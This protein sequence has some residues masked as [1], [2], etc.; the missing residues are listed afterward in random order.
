[1]SSITAPVR[2]SAWRRLLLA[3][4]AILAVVLTGVVVPTAASAVESALRIDKKVDGLELAELVPGDEF[5]YTVDLTCLDEDCVDVELVDTLPA[6]LAGFRLVGASYEPADLPLAVD[7]EGCVEDGSGAAVEVTDDCSFRVDFLQDLGDGAV[8]LIAGGTLKLSLVL[9]VPDDLSPDWP[10]NGATITN[11]SA[12]SWSNGPGDLPASLTDGADVVITVAEVIDVEASKEWSPASQQFEPGDVSTITLGAQNLSNLSAEALVVQD[13]MSAVDGAAELGADNPFRIVDFQGFGAQALPADATTVTVDAYV[14]DT[15]SETW[16]WV[17]GAAGA[18]PALPTGVEPADVGGVRLTFAGGS[19]QPDATASTAFTVAQ[20]AADRDSGATLSGGASL[21]N[22]VSATVVVPGRDGVSDEATAPFEVGPLTVDVSGSKSIEPGELPAGG[23]ATA[24]LGVVN[25]SNGP[26]DALTISDLGFFDADMAFGGFPDGIG[27]PTGATEASIVWYVDGAPLPAEAF[28]DGASPP[29]PAGTVTGFVVE[30]RGDIPAGEGASL[31]ATIEP[32]LGLVTETERVHRRTNTIDVTATNAVG[33]AADDASDEIVVYYPEI[34]IALDKAIRPGGA[35]EPGNSVVTSLTATTGSGVAQVDPTHIAVEDSWRED[36]PDDF[37]NAFDIAG[38]AP[39]QVPPRTTLTVEYQRPDGSWATAAVVPPQDGA[40]IVQLSRAELAAALTAPDTLADVTGIR[41]SFDNPEG[42]PQGFS[43]IPNV[44]FDARS[45][46]RDG[47]GPVDPRD[48]PEDSQAAQ[49]PTIYENEATAQSHGEVEGLP[50]GIDSELVDAHD[51]VGVQTPATGVGPG[52]DVRKRWVDAVDRTADVDVVDAQSGA[53]VTTRNEWRTGTPGLQTL[54]LSDPAAAPGTDPAEPADTVF[55]AFDL[56]R[57]DRITLADDPL[58]AWDDV[59][60]VWLF[61]DGAWT[62][63]A[64]DGGTWMDPD[65]SFRGHQLTPEQS[66]GTTGVRLVYVPDDAARAASSD[67]TRPEAGSGIARSAVDQYRP[68]LLTWQLRNV[69]RDPAGLADP[70]VTQGQSFNDPDEGTVWNSLR[71]DWTSTAGSGSDVDRDAIALVDQ[72]PLV[73][74]QKRATPSSVTVPEAADVDPADYPT[75]DF[76]L[77][78]TNDST[79]RASYLRVTDPIPCAAGQADECVSA[80]DAWDGDP[81]AGAAYDPARNPYEWLAVRSLSFT[82]PA[83]EVDPASSTVTLWDRAPDGALSTRT[84]SATAAEGLD[85]AA[86]ETVVGVS[87]VFQGAAPETSGGTIAASSQVGVGIRTQVRQFER[88]DPGELVSARRIDNDAIAQSYDPVLFPS[89]AASTPADQDGASVQLRTG[90]LDVELAKTIAPD[91]LLE[92]G[93]GTPVRV[94]LDAADGDSTVA[95]QQVTIADADPGFWNAIRL[96]DAPNLAVVLPAGADQV[97]VDALVDGAWVEGVFAASAVLP[98]VPAADVTGLRAV[99]RD[100]AGE[101][102]SR[103]SPPADWQARLAFDVLVLTTQ[104]DGAELSLPARFHN[105]AT[106]S[107]ER[108]DGRYSPADDA[109]G[110]DLAV[111]PG[112]RRIDVVKSHPGTSHIVPI[113]GVL[114]WTLAFTNTGTGYLT[115]EE[116]VDTLPAH[117]EWDFVDPVFATSA[118]G[119]LSTDVV[120]TADGTGKVL[121]FRW[122]EGGRTMSPGETFT[123]AIGLSLTPGLR[124]DEWATNAFVV[125]TAEELDACTNTGNGEG[126]IAGLPADQCG[127]T[128]YVQPAPGGSLSATKHVRGEIDGDLVDGQ[129]NLNNPDAACPI[130][131][132]GYTRTPCAAYTAVGAT[133]DWKLTVLNSGTVGFPTLSIVDPLPRPGDR[134]LATGAARGSTFGPVLLPQSLGTNSLP[135]GTVVRLDVTTSPSPCVGTDPTP[136]WEGDLHCDTTASWVP[137]LDYAGEWV[138]VTGMRV[139]FD[140]T[141]TAAGELAPGQSLGLHYQTRNDPATAAHPEL[142]PIAVRDQGGLAWNQIGAVGT[143]RAGQRYAVAPVK[144]GVTLLH[145]DLGVAKTLEGAVE[146][147]PEAFE[148]QAVC[149]VA[150]APLVLPGDGIVTVTRDGGLDGRVDGL[151]LGSVCDVTERGPVGRYGEESRTGDGQR[152]IITTPASD[153]AEI[154]TVQTVAIANVYVTPPVTPPVSP[155]GG[156][157]AVTGLDGERVGLLALLGALLVL[158]GGGA[159]LHRRRAAAS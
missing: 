120:V 112:T 23:T 66:L 14:Y 116:L 81:F 95:T 101:V 77:T 39:T 121:G 48:E 12:A 154:P 70:W 61:L 13:P 47:S 25:E 76:A 91:A 46:L 24:T 106:A 108:L 5:T 3:C 100:A 130:D 21:T 111:D 93:L 149:T 128:N 18:L 79:A 62:Q 145:G 53:V 22:A 90:V 118:G 9:Q 89:G 29:P 105:V 87:V 15:D 110:A 78:A 83:G 125:T 85:A 45:E 139:T 126:T 88:S 40:Q 6:E 41:F 33:T 152:V 20:R 124:F 109:A 107:S 97:R 59:S 58:L 52:A 75:I 8:G 80:P 73:S 153:G 150:G 114:P 132:E 138:D 10:H 99:F 49:E 131:D 4:L 159:A 17:P 92:A 103:T 19:I 67:P 72:P 26:V 63:L 37:W 16:T 115:V 28:A 134:M 141:G 86:L 127:T 129:V 56:L 133:D 117:L 122:P 68:S 57:I 148:F 123:I 64:P 96:A 119:T 155:P 32:A 113:G 137:V 156:G 158:V 146:L 65:G 71:A 54:T 104:R 140:F 143:D 69:V 157:I 27:Y 98:S 135:E 151:P 36:R 44:V 142:A 51:T 102:F 60:E 94:S 42:F 84:L 43:V 2:S 144:A 35:V 31:D 147:A 11:T 34:D 1:M 38:I 30:F 74:V 82:Y 136:A 50:G 7:S 55:Q